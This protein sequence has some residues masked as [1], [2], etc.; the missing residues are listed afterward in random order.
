MAL[1]LATVTAVF[2]G[3][4]ILG[5]RERREF[6]HDEALPLK[7]AIRA[8]LTNRDFLYFLGANLMVQFVFIALTSTIP[9][10]T[11]YV[12][13]IQSDL[14]LPALGLTLDVATQNSLFLALTFIIALPA[15]PVW[16]WLSRRRGAWQAMRLACLTAAASL[17]AF[18]WPA[19]FFTGLACALIFG[20]S[21][22]GLLMLPD[23][24]VADTVDADELTTGARREGL[25]FGMNGFIIRFAFTIQGLITAI[26]LTL[27]GYV[28]PTATTLYPAQPAAALLGIRLMLAGLPALAMLLAFFCLGGYS[29]H[30]RRLAEVQASVRALHARKQAALEEIHKEAA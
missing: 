22:S 15:M 21:L 10:Y 5:S 13:R 25:Y 9:F 3:L 28:A 27:T 11:K 23:L 12:L 8:T 1:L 29:L 30:G 4:S 24:L 2:F 7:Q 6:R 19:N 26:V 17:L 20:L 16:T 18:F 14:A